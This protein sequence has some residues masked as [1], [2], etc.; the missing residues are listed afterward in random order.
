M[1][2][3]IIRKLMPHPTRITE[4][5]VIKKLGPKL[6][7]P[8]IWHVNR[9]SVSGAIAVGLF[10]AVMPIPFQMLLAAT[11]AILF[12]VNILIAVPTVWVSNPFTIAPIFYYCYQVG[13]SILGSSRQA[14]N[15]ELSFS[16]LANELHFI[17]QP[18]LLGCL[19]VASVSA[20][21]GYSFVRLLWRYLIWQQIRK[22]QNRYT[23]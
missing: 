19:V 13:I 15:F 16:W 7:D 21:V 3:K 18:F 14:F 20:F 17:W 8:G 12:H 6:Q 10:C 2:R 23:D 22:R 11:M 9:R 4:N 5:S 1:P